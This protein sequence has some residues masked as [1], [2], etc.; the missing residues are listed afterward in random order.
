MFIFKWLQKFETALEILGNKN[1]NSKIL[2]QVI[3][4][5]YI[6]KGIFS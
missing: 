2:N 5:Y 1:E 3:Y 6:I 4:L